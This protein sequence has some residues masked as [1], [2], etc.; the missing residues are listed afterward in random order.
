MARLLAITPN[1]HGIDQHK[2]EGDIEACIRGF[3]VC[4]DWSNILAWTQADVDQLNELTYV[5]RKFEKYCLVPKASRC[6][7][8]STL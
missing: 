5:E 2:F 4:P 1:R 8:S 6:P 7:S 3:V